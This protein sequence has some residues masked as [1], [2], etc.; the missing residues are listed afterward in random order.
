M[1]L[2]I[3]QVIAGDVLQFKIVTIWTVICSC[4]YPVV[5]PSQICVAVNIRVKHVGELQVC[6]SIHHKIGRGISLKE[7]CL[8]L[9]GELDVNRRSKFVM[10]L[11]NIWKSRTVKLWDNVNPN[12]QTVINSAAVFFFFLHTGFEHNSAAD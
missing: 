3:K 1:S 10:N 8:T 4:V 5:F 6:G 12:H 2:E 11:W 9:L 7:V